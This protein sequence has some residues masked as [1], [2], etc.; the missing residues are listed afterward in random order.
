MPCS[1]AAVACSGWLRQ[2]GIDLPEP[3]IQLDLQDD[4][5]GRMKAAHWKCSIGR[6]LRICMGSAT[7]SRS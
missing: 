5:R 7:S 2:I 4:R 1:A 3:H 6:L